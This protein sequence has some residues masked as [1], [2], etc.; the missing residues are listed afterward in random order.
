VASTNLQCML[1]KAYVIVS[2]CLRSYPHELTLTADKNKFP[3]PSSN[4]VKAPVPLA[5]QPE[6]SQI[7]AKSRKMYNMVIIQHIVYT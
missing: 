1:E 4:G 2:K 5:S 7:E 3:P 6:A